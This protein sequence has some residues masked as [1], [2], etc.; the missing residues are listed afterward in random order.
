M[1]V[2]ARVAGVHR[3]AFRFTRSL[4]PPCIYL[5]EV[6]ENQEFDSCSLQLETSRSKTRTTSLQGKCHT[7][8]GKSQDSAGQTNAFDLVLVASAATWS[9]IGYTRPETLLRVRY[10]EYVL[11]CS[12]R[13]M[14]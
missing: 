1:G 5:G 8:L 7:L 2:D 14:V 10:V 11:A 3:L 6:L 9:N 12:H 4:A 13:I